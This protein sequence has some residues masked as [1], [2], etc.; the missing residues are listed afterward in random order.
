MKK[1]K[2]AVNPSDGSALINSIIFRTHARACEI[3]ILRNDILFASCNFNARC[4]NYLR[5]DD[6]STDSQRKCFRGCHH[7]RSLGFLERAVVCIE[8]TREALR[9]RDCARSFALACLANASLA[10]EEDE[11]EER[12]W[13]NLY[14]GCRLYLQPHIHAWKHPDNNTA[15]VPRAS[16]QPLRRTREKPI[17]WKITHKTCMNR[18]FTIPARS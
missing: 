3:F 7:H 17:S 8:T 4:C 12:Y 9:M 14:S 15:H 18:R 10:R 13:R 2:N 6:T 5:P 16:L 11:E 1:K